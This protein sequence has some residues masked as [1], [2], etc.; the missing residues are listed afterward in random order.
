MT[1]ADDAD[2]A[3]KPGIRT[4][5]RSKLY[6]SVV[7]QLIRTIS[8]G[9][10]PPGSALPSERQLASQLG[11]SRGSLREALRVLEHAGVLNARPGSGTFVAPDGGSRSSFIRARAAIVG[12]HS[13]LDIIVARAAVEPVCASHAATSRTAHDLA[14]IRA[15]LDEQI[16]LAADGGD[17]TE[18]DNQFHLAIAAASR[19]VVLA[20]LEQTLIRLMYESTWTALKKR[21]RE[22]WGQRFIEHHELI[23]DAIAAGDPRRA[24]Q[25]MA[26]HMTAIETTLIA[27]ASA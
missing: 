14:I 26:M 17:V 10:F 22:H 1:A 6:A 8:A 11:V 2:V 9:R 18:A 5:E 21:S 19:N 24:H 16:S 13:P 7:D 3:G 4:I 27:E 15:R 12:E 25:L 20:S 23:Y